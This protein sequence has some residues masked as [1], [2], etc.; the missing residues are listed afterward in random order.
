M[1]NKQRA[2]EVNGKDY[3]I[4]AIS[5]A[6]EQTITE[7]HEQV[8][9]GS[10]PGP[11]GISADEA[12]GQLYTEALRRPEDFEI[13]TDENWEER[14]SAKLKPDP[15]VIESESGRDFSFLLNQDGDSTTP[16]G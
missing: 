11:D 10:H 3:Y 16:P 7:L 13:Y 8:I 15:I 2:I 1:G 4:F 9:L 14:Q 6:G 5:T 12:M